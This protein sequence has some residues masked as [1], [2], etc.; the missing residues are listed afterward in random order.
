MMADDSIK[1]EI[2]GLD[3]L[4]KALQQFPKEVGK[5][6]EQAGNE[7]SNE[8]LKEQGLRVY[9][10]PGPG[11]SPPVPYYIRGRGMQYGNRN[12]LSS[13]RLGTQW[14]VKSENMRTTIANR[15]S[16]AKWVH[17]KEQARAM[18]RIGWKKLLDV[19][20]DKQARITVIYNQWVDRL[21][22]KLNL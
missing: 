22:R 4:M 7:A 8:I 13:E 19:A 18:E 12:T 5:T 17:G 10:S 9:P 21:L 16:Y 3:K 15:A 20:Q 1:I 14:T 6:V 2:V 11:N